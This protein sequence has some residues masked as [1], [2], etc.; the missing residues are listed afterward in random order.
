MTE[1]LLDIC[2]P[3]SGMLFAKKHSP[4]IVVVVIGLTSAIYSSYLLVSTI[5]LTYPLWVAYGNIEK[6]PY[7]FGLYNFVFVV[8]ALLADFRKKEPVLV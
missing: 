1:C 6:I 3:G 4:A 7:F 8:R 2:L 5:Y